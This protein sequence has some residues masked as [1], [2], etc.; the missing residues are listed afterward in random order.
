ADY[1]STYYGWRS[2]SRLTALSGG[3]DEGWLT[4]KERK[5][6]DQSWVW[7][8]PPRLFTY[9][10]IEKSCGATVTTL[11][12]LHQWDESLALLSPSA[13]PAV[14]SFLLA[15]VNLPLDAVN[16]AR[17]DLKGKPEGGELWQVAY[18][19][20]YASTV[21][22]TAAE[23]GLDPLLVHALIREESRYNPM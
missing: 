3:K 22:R 12:R 10:Q 9:E 17:A 21:S 11:V 14:R 18:P 15:M 16:S 2:L 19:L 23:Q 13:L 4:S 20:L 8:E 1:P 7:P 6:P 5:Y